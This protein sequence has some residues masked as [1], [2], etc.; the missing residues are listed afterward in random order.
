MKL[1]D[2]LRKLDCE[3]LTG[4]VNMEEEVKYGYTSDL[5]SEVMGKARQD[6]IW[7]TVQ[8]HLNIVA[9]AVLVGIKAIIV[10]G[11][12]KVDPKIAE[13]AK[14]EGVALVLAKDNA[15]IVSGKLYEI[16]LR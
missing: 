10:C 14:Q 1:K 15:F 9:V 4:D 7:I 8:S 12:K 2:I 13:K 16:G 6:S 3:V 5:L 11:G